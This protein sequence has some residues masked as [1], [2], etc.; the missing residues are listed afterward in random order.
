MDPQ[1]GSGLLEQKCFRSADPTRPAKIRQNRDLTRLTGPSDPW[2]TLLGSR[3]KSQLSTI[4]V[5]FK[6][7][8]FWR[9]MDRFKKKKYT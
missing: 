3:A 8:I 5:R 2:T 1:K 9:S 4:L 7:C 6:E